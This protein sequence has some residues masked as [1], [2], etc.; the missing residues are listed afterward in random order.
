[1][2]GPEVFGLAGF[3]A[4]VLLHLVLIWVVLNRR[5]RQR[6]ETLLLFLLA[7]LLLWYAGNL[8]GFLLRQ[9]RIERV[10][11]PLQWVDTL[12]FAGLSLLPAFLLHTH[13]S[14]FQRYH[15]PAARDRRLI[16][17]LLAGLYALLLFLPAALPYLFSDLAIQPLQK[18]GPFRLPFLWV[19]SLSYFGCAYLQ[20]RIL[21]HPR[22]PV[23]KSLFTRLLP[24]F[25]LIP[26][27][28][29]YVF[30][31][32]GS[33]GPAGEW[34]VVLGLQ[35]SLAPTLVVAYYIYRH[36][37]LQIPVQRSIASALVI[38][39]ILSA[40][41]LGIRRFGQYLQQELEA[42]GLLVE[43]IFLL[44]ILLFFAPL[45]RGLEALV[46]RLFRSEM[47]KFR[48][49]GEAVNRSTGHFLDPA[50]LKEFTEELLNREL[51]LYWVR[52][53]L[54]ETPGDPP[55][56]NPE[57]MVFPLT[58][59]GRVMGNLHVR[60][61][62]TRLSPAEQEALRML[63]NEIATALERC[64]L[65]ENKINLERELARKSRMEE[66]GRM[67]AAVAHNVKNP[68]SSMKTLLQLQQEAGNLTAE[69]TR[70]VGMMIREIDRLAKTVNELLKFS[71]LDESTAPASPAEVSLR[72]LLDSLQA[73]FRGDLEARSLHL[74][75]EIE[76]E[77]L[78]LFS[79]A[80]LLADILSNLLSNAI[81]ASSPEG[82][83]W[84]RAVREGDWLQVS[85]EDEGPGIPSAL[86]SRIF[87]PF[88]TSKS[89]GTGL[90][91][92]IVRRRTQQL[93]GTIEFESPIR[94]QKGARFVLRLP[95]VP[96]E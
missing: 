30:Q 26:I 21:Q 47:K 58:A 85:V 74:E 70:E 67:A 38:L 2:G 28:N 11:V 19:L 84:L 32:G 96:M 89:R 24:F 36:Q 14:Y 13:W 22:N 20:L 87:E 3:F 50:L 92:A 10:S 88:V 79:D 33:E 18:L 6:L 68:L 8:L 51:P 40:Y 66:L 54:G 91:L 48:E 53:A 83:I 72:P 61:A 62:G 35:A 71:R 41:L 94:R 43:I 31:G 95:C 60:P 1:M 73:L 49:L 37:F 82:W 7:G 42:P 86:G 75:V 76:P 29:F 80:D 23:E 4:G 55:G 12:S 52:I 56:S 93:K 16:L 9:M 78:V 45:S 57:G 64:Q 34:M 5:D 69:Q 59:G 65:L 90:G 44:T 46:E 27:F 77:P 25:L 17:P 15:H 63:S 39:L 81:E